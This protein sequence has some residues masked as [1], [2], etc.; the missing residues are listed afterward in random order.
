MSA[1]NCRR[2]IS[3]LHSLPKLLMDETLLLQ[4]MFGK[5]NLPGKV[6]VL[7]Q[8]KHLVHTI[9]THNALC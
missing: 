4:N 5:N 1:L 8:N 7:C 6:G 2:L 9:S 3:S